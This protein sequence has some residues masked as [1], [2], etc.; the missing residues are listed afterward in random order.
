MA[1]QFTLHDLW[2][3]AANRATQHA[4]MEAVHRR[5]M[6]GERLFAFFDDVHVVTTPRRVGDVYLVLLE[7]LFR[8]SRIRINV[9]KT[10]VWNA[11]GVRPQ[12][13]DMLERIAVAND[14]NA[15]VWRIGSLTDPSVLIEDVQSA[16]SLLVH[17]AGARA[18]FFLRVIRFELVRTFA[19]GP[20]RGLWNCL[21]HILSLDSQ[22]D[23]TMRDI[24]SLPLSM[25]GLGLRSASRTS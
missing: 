18:N 9:G 7:E 25:G 1:Q 19:E 20:N 14:P 12:A 4:A 6:E 3:K 15:R 5:L 11:G 23:G 16:L 21:H 2:A 17:C 22:V 24:G 10:R 13:C 8:H